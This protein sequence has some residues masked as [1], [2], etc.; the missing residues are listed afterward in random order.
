M[1]K[2]LLLLLLLLLSIFFTGIQAQE[3]LES[4]QIIVL[5]YGEL[6]PTQ[7]DLLLKEGLIGKN[8]QDRTYEL[9]E[10]E[11]SILKDNK[12]DFEI[13]EYGFEIK[14]DESSHDLE[15][16]LKS[17]TAEDS[18]NDN[19]STDYTIADLS[20]AYS[21][22]TISGAP[23]GVYASRIIYEWNIDHDYVSDVYLKCGTS[24][25]NDGEIRLSKTGDNLWDGYN[26][27]SEG[28]RTSYPTNQKVNQTWTLVATDKLSGDDGRI[29]S[30]KITVYYENSPDLYISNLDVT[31]TQVTPG[32]KLN[33]SCDVGNKGT[34]STNYALV[35]LKYY[36]S[37]DRYYSST[38]IEIGS[39]TFGGTSSLS[40]GGTWDDTESPTIDKSDLPKTSGTCY[41]IAYIDV[42]DN[43]EELDEDNNAD[44]YVALPIYI[45]TPDIEVTRIWTDPSTPVEGSSSTIYVTF[46]NNGDE[47]AEDISLTYYVDGSNVGSDSHG[48]LDP[49]DTRTEDISYT[50]NSDGNHDILVVVDKIINPEAETVTGNNDLEITVD[51]DPEPNPDFE[52]T[53]YNVHEPLEI[54]PG[55]SID[56]DLKFKNT[57]T[58]ATTITDYW[59]IK[60]YLS[61]DSK[62]DDGD[63]IQI[64]SEDFGITAIMS[65]NEIWDDTKSITI[66]ESD[67]LSPHNP[68]YLIAQIDQP[69][70]INELF[71]DNNTAY[72]LI[73][74]Q[75]PANLVSD[76][77][78][79]DFASRESSSST[80]LSFTLTNTGD[81][82]AVGEISLAGSDKE[83]YTII[84][85]GG[86][87]NIIANE[88]KTINVQYNPSGYG[89]DEARVEINGS[90]CP[91][92]EISLTGHCNNPPIVS[93]VEPGSDYIS[94]NQGDSK[95]FIAN[96]IDNDKNLYRAKWYYDAGLIKDEIIDWGLFESH[97]DKDSELTDYIFE[98]EGNHK[99]VCEFWDEEGLKGEVE[100]NVV[101]VETANVTFHVLENTSNFKAGAL[102]KI[103]DQSNE[104]NQWSE[105]TNDYGYYIFRLP[106]TS[107]Y[108]YHVFNSDVA[109]E[110]QELWAKN[111]FE[112]EDGVGAIQAQRSY[113]HTTWYA[114]SNGNTIFYPGDDKLPVNANLNLDINIKNNY[115]TN[116]TSRMQVWLDTDK[117]G[118]AE[119]ESGLTQFTANANGNTSVAI[120]FTVQEDWL[121][122]TLYV[123][124]KIE[125]YIDGEWIITDILDWEEC[126]AFTIDDVIDE[127]PPTIIS[128]FP[129]DGESIPI[130]LLNSTGIIIEFSDEIDLNTLTT[131]SLIISQQAQNLNWNI[132]LDKSSTNYVYID[133]NSTL[134]SAYDLTCQI[135]T[136]V[137]DLAGNSLEAVKSWTFN[138][139]TTECYISEFK[140]NRTLNS[141]GYYEMSPYSFLTFDR[142]SIMSEDGVGYYSYTKNVHEKFGIDVSVTNSLN[143]D[144]LTGL[145]YRIIYPNGDIYESDHTYR[146]NLEANSTEQV[147]FPVG[148]DKEVVPGEY[149]VQIVTFLLPEPNDLN[150]E[151]GI[152][153]KCL[154]NDNFPD[155]NDQTF[156][157]HG[158][159][160]QYDLETILPEVEYTDGQIAYN[161]FASVF[162]TIM[163]FGQP[164]PIINGQPTAEGNLLPYVGGTGDFFTPYKE[165]V[166][167]AVRTDIDKVSED[168]GQTTIKTQWED[169]SV[170]VQ[171]G[172]S[173]SVS[174]TFYFDRAT[175]F[176]DIKSDLSNDEL[177]FD[178]NT[179]F[180]SVYTLL[181]DENNK[182]LIGIWHDYSIDKNIRPEGWWFDN[183]KEITINHQGDIEVMFSASLEFG[184][185]N[186]TPGT[187]GGGV[188]DYEK[189]K[190][191]PEDVNWM[192]MATG[193]ENRDFKGSYFNGVESDLTILEP[194]NVKFSVKPRTSGKYKVEVYDGDGKLNP[195]NWEW[196]NTLDG[197]YS[198]NAGDE[199]IFNFEVTPETKD[200]E[201]S[202]HIKKQSW[203]PG[204]YFTKE[205]VV[206]PLHASGE[207][208]VV[209]TDLP[210]DED[211][212]SVDDAIVVND[213]GINIKFSGLPEIPKVNTVYNLKIDI[214]VGND[215]DNDYGAAY[216]KDIYGI[217]MSQLLFHYNS[218][219]VELLSDQVQLEIDGN[220][221]LQEAIM[222]SISLFTLGKGE[223]IAST[224]GGVIKNEVKDLATE[225]LVHFGI[226]ATGKVETHY[227]NDLELANVGELKLLLGGG[228][229]L[230]NLATANNIS[231]NLPIKFKTDGEH[232]LSFTP[233]LR[234]NALWVP[235]NTSSEQNMTG[236]F[237]DMFEA[238]K[239]YLLSK[240]VSSSVPDTPEPIAPTLNEEIITL[241]PLFNW[242][243]YNSPDGNIQVGYELR[244]RCDD[245]N[246]NIVYETGFI[247]GTSTTHSYSSGT[248]SGVDPVTGFEKISEE[249]VPGKKYHWHVRVMD[250]VGNWS[251]W[252]SDDPE[253]HQVF[254]TKQLDNE[255]PTISDQS[256]SID[257]NT[258]AATLIGNIN[259]NDP[260]GGE[261]TYSFYDGQTSPFVLGASSGSL[262]V[263]DEGDFNFEE[264]Q[265]YKFRVK[266]TDDG[267]PEASSIAEVTVNLNDV[268]DLPRVRNVEISPSNPT[269]NQNLN[270][271]YDYSDED[272]DGDNSIIEWYQNGDHQADFDGMSLVASEN[273]ASGDEWFVKIGPYDGKENGTIKTSNTVE[274][275]SVNHSPIDLSLSSSVLFENNSVN[276]VI[277]ILKVVDSDDG[278]TH[279]FEFVDGY[280]DNNAFTIDSEGNLRADIVFDFE[281]KTD[282]S[283]AIKATDNAGAS[284]I[285]SFIINILDE[286][287]IPGV[288]NVTINPVSPEISESLTLSYTFIDEDIDEDNSSI[289]WYRNNIYLSDYNDLI[290]IS[291]EETSA[292][293]IWY[294]IVEPNDGESQ[295]ISVKSNEV[296]I[297]PE[298]DLQLSS[299]LSGNVS[300]LGANVLYNVTILGEWSYEF[301]Q[302]ETLIAS[303][304]GTGNGSFTLPVPKNSSNGEITFKLSVSGCD[305]YV[306]DEYINQD[307]NPYVIDA[308]FDALPTILVVNNPVLFN[309]LSTGN[310]TNWS[311]NFGDGVSSIV[312]NPNHS[313]VSSGDYTISLTASNSEGEDTEV[314]TAYI[315]VVD[316]P[317]AIDVEAQD[318]T[319]NCENGEI[320]YQSWLDNHGGARAVDLGCG[321]VSWNYTMD[322]YTPGRCNTGSYTVTF[323]AIGDCGVSVSTTATFTIEDITPPVF[324]IIP[325]D[326]VVECDGSGNISQLQAWLKNVAAIDDCC[327]TR[328][329]ITNDY[330][331][332]SNQCAETGSVLVTWTAIDS[333]GNSATTSAT[334]TVTDTKGPLF[335]TIPKD[336]VV[337]CDGSDYSSVINEWLA[338]VN[339][340]DSCGGAVDINNDFNSLSDICGS[341]GM[342]EVTWTAEDECGNKT[343]A[344]ASFTVEDTTP[345]TYTIPDDI[346][347]YMDENA[348]FDADTSITGDVKDEADLCSTSI[349]AT[350]A[351][352]T[353]Q[354][355]CG[356]LIKRTWSLE[357][358]CGNF[359]SDQV[360]NIE[361]NDNI[362]P[363]VVCN[364]VSVVLGS[365]GTY[366]LGKSN[367]ET[368][369]NGSTDNYDSFS[370]LIISANPNRFDCDD[371]GKSIPVT[372]TVTDGCG[373]SST[374]ITSV[375]VLDN[376]DPVVSTIAD[377][378]VKLDPGTCETKIS[379]PQITASDNCSITKELITGLGSNGTF[380]IGTTTEKWSVTDKSGNETML[381][382]KVIVEPTNDAP[383]IDSINDIDIFEGEGEINVELHGISYG[384]DCENQSVEVSATCANTDLVTNIDVNYLQGEEEGSIDV[385]LA[386]NVIGEGNI[387][388]IVEDSEGAKATQIFKLVVKSQPTIPVV[389]QSIPDTSF[390]SNETVTISISSKL[391]EYFNDSG[392]DSITISVVEQSTMSLPD[393]MSYENDSLLITPGSSD[394][395]CYNMIVTAT[396][397]FSNSVSDT[398][399]VCIKSSEINVSIETIEEG[400]F[401]VSM[402]P[403]PSSGMVNIKFGDVGTNNIELFV[404]NING[405][406]ILHKQYMPS[407][408]IRFDLADKVSGIYFV[409]IISDDREVVKKLVLK[410]N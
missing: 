37:S 130:E 14:S 92:L 339:A 44:E 382:F 205:K 83:K 206:L 200:E 285:Q 6:S 385:Q 216:P 210:Y 159:Q 115:N 186:S 65:I 4:K 160:C 62:F 70:R 166:I 102:V 8:W 372:L 194:G 325:K 257:E 162:N 9:Y 39:R 154:L 354:T 111:N 42:N 228:S 146:F 233:D 23:S 329:V 258:L 119:F 331:S 139:Q 199:Q 175:C 236:S 112:I 81:R 270:L 290:T 203:I 307:L 187:E 273:T 123:K 247:T 253:P 215:W 352:D 351:D 267:N 298:C 183:N 67:L 53:E 321:N 369:A 61:S 191:N 57:G 45:K 15:E 56:L 124:V 46:E 143:T 163:L 152:T 185:F 221:V 256:F 167:N 335:T 84:S 177:S 223:I 104:D 252:S 251:A 330:T 232:N 242:T 312:Q 89:D 171:L 322:D 239:Q 320:D 246:D 343:T 238:R 43:I 334:F 387:T 390:Y 82:D 213:G 93:K 237:Y 135:N 287:D 364:S 204:I 268:N 377:V 402:Y 344:S 117:T 240:T 395:L 360:Q 383:S 145:K 87:F 392:S 262:W 172:E 100:W 68:C 198:L 19:N 165:A 7:V 299:D 409:K 114:A 137:K 389:I 341:T 380:P 212:R 371:A 336:T 196:V 313:Y 202:F 281:Y 188:Y 131:S 291:S 29:D 400:L 164:K 47:V 282:Y 74:I 250:E 338:K 91:D 302:G 116:F 169:Q 79:L 248:F 174:Q 361:V 346:V 120:P 348:L 222:A 367:L 278:D 225:A 280:I 214:T 323:T 366:T 370:D 88:I 161:L 208:P 179:M 16:D 269:S 51:V 277:G 374:C 305:G 384:H 333:T 381:S 132:N 255:A 288:S 403:N 408:L 283:I 76:K 60:Y 58:K 391:G 118:S 328:I 168:V 80:E 24:S 147:S 209:L 394:T 128:V 190:T 373:N 310:P 38:D 272:G 276:D 293:E 286:N 259:A 297:V 279:Q 274:I 21:N 327:D 157:H 144:E 263:G 368:L 105:L 71:E 345:P 406:R 97:E 11:V 241:T 350:Y 50:F 353:T 271:S 28:S 386:P 133:I 193:V 308:D 5:Q 32:E 218:D 140:T 357:D 158:N 113:P 376:S 181:D 142:F 249:L 410:K 326:T 12:I 176:V 378:I 96:G 129:E 355:D 106:V 375:N 303:G 358:N 217:G 337:E 72:K 25:W 78:S 388:V 151:S 103:I 266:V 13:I 404:Y 66:N 107:S 153:L 316:Q 99:I 182:H 1:K 393:W 342:A 110:E 150:W 22:I 219:N 148:A 134:S 156:L 173:A 309:D 3:A 332:L 300:Y 192:I 301:K 63:D 230:F 195:I 261:L 41:L 18:E 399:T 55:E 295:G 10:N 365:S 73:T 108:E 294:A 244:V 229:S 125:T 260:E 35:V 48:S 292:N 94:I 126:I 289:K 284:I 356:W 184:P 90:N 86:A 26:E 397:L 243:S 189:W 227:T 127:T 379:Y 136:D 101:V 178:D 235:D 318:Q 36:L 77:S 85:G 138:L 211:I 324:T 141:Y 234:V 349:E 54:I 231:L 180:S 20:A 121:G 69:N 359:A 27:T 64:A 109:V 245:D 2:I 319:S 30:W 362:A 149:K 207:F 95:R 75:D 311:W 98:T 224:I 314:K 340:T 304:N 220:T 407:E 122:K 296:T 401:E 155:L 59:Q 34:K 363:N 17:A 40:P 306:K 275:G 52:F 398:F 33:I 170:S 49:G 197:P 396:N 347:I 317:L 31:E 264:N 405:A 315:K 254:Y 226:G 201:F 265:Q